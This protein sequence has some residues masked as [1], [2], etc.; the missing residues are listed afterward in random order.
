MRSRPFFKEVAGWVP[1][2][3][4]LMTLGVAGLGIL[5]YL[6]TRSNI[7]SQA[8]SAPEPTPTRSTITALGR[9]EPKDGVVKIAAPSGGAMRVGRLRVEEGD[10]VQAGQVI[11]EMDNQSQL[12]AAVRQAEA[13]V[14]EAEQQLAQV[15]AGAKP[16]DIEVERANVARLEVERQQAQR[17]YDR[18]LRLYGEGAISA[19]ELDDRQLRVETIDRQLEQARQQLNSV[20]DVRPVDV[21]LARSRVE[22]AITNLNRAQADL[23]NALVRAPI[24]GQIIK[25]QTDA[26]EEVGENGIVEMGNTA[27]MYVVAEIY[28]TDIGQVRAGQ[29]ATITSS[30]FPGQSITGTVEQVGLAV[31]RNDVLSSD[32]TADMDTRVVEVKIRLN[33]SAAVSGLTNL[34]VNVAIDLD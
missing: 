6:N 23:E 12:E 7:P 1:A 17:D 16:A 22:V 21:D 4:I 29:T 24:S 11:A 20:R 15:Q 27:Q 3:L 28:E 30:T 18:Y 26:G 31:N 25:I 14:R 10:R 9:I 19:A 5:T 8:E 2:V 33:D 34:Q 32:P 13:Q